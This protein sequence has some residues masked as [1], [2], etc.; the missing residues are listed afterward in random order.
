MVKVADTVENVVTGGVT[1]L[2]ALGTFIFI[3]YLPNTASFKGIIKLN[4][5]NDQSQLL[6]WKQTMQACLQPVIR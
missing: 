3:G 2:P 4:D 5:K 1:Y 6:K